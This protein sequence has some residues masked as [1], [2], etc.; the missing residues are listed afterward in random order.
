MMA[1]QQDFVRF[2]LGDLEFALALASVERIVRA[3]AV[4]SLPGA[5]AAVL[6]VVNVHGDVLPVA[7]MRQR[8]G[9]ERRPVHPDDHL[10]LART[11]RRR[12][13]LAVDEARGIVQC[14]ED[15]IISADT[16]VPGL[17]HVHGIARTSGALLLIHDL[18][19]FLGLGE[20]AALQQALDH[21]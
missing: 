8:F 5:P 1:N 10:V 19:R 12:L 15:E 11:A 6:G 14:D 3:V 21:G 18:D 9:L 4:T 13:A 17:E 16:V 7:D 20:E 2:S